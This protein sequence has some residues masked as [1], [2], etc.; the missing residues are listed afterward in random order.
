MASTATQTWA[1]VLRW[2]DD[3]V[4][5]GQYLPLGRMQKISIGSSAGYVPPA[6]DPYITQFGRLIDLREKQLP[7]AQSPDRS[8]LLVTAPLPVGPGGTPVL[9]D[10]PDPTWKAGS[11]TREEIEG[12]VA[13][14]VEKDQLRKI[15]QRLEDRTQERLQGTNILVFQPLIRLTFQPERDKQLLSRVW[16]IEFR[17]D[18]VGVHGAMLVDMKT[19]W[20][21]FLG[22][23][24]DIATAQGE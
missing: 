21:H 10:L 14:P 12:K 6:A 22:G 5:T 16:I 13:R 7:I 20:I 2:R 8:Q 4:R 1:D 11:W 17:P 9:P 23:L 15:P 19:G 3:L 18:P 24:I